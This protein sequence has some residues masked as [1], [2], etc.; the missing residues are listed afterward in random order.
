MPSISEKDTTIG[1]I[2]NRNTTAD[3]TRKSQQNDGQ[4]DLEFITSKKA[5]LDNAKHEQKSL[6]QKVGTLAVDIAT[7]NPLAKHVLT[8][9]LGTVMDQ[10]SG[11][12]QREAE[13]KK[14]LE[15]QK[16]L[17]NERVKSWLMTKLQFPTPEKIIRIH[18]KRARGLKGMDWKLFK[19][20]TSDPYCT[21]KIGGRMHRT[22]TVSDT[23]T[24]VW[25]PDEFYD[26]FLFDWKQ[27]MSVEVFDE[28]MGVVGRALFGEGQS[29]LDDDLG[30]SDVFLSDFISMK[31]RDVTKWLTLYERN[32]LGQRQEACGEIELR[33]QLFNLRPCRNVDDYRLFLEAIKNKRTENTEELELMEKGIIKRKAIKHSLGGRLKQLG[34]KIAGTKKGKDGKRRKILTKI[35][36]HK[37][38]NNVGNETN[39]TTLMSVANGRKTHQLALPNKEDSRS[40]AIGRPS[41]PGEDENDNTDEQNLGVTFVDSDGE[42]VNEDEDIYEEYEPTKAEIR[43][44]REDALANKNVAFLQANLNFVTF[45]PRQV[46]GDEELLLEEEMKLLHLDLEKKKERQRRKQRRIKRRTDRKFGLHAIQQHRKDRNSAQNN[47]DKDIDAH[48]ETEANNSETDNESADE[49]WQSAMIAM[50]NKKIKDSRRAIKRRIKDMKTKRKKWK[51]DINWNPYQKKFLYDCC[52]ITMEI[53]TREQ[54]SWYA[55]IKEDDGAIPGQ[56]DP[57]KDKD[58]DEKKD[59]APSPKAQNLDTYK[60][61]LLDPEN[62]DDEDFFEHSSSSSSDSDISNAGDHANQFLKL[63]RHASK[64]YDEDDDEEAKKGKE[65]L[66]MSMIP[67]EVDDSHSEKENNKNSSA[68]QKNNS[69]PEHACLI[70]E[71]PTFEDALKESYNGSFL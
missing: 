48:S 28:D 12:A 11:K 64:S 52:T 68:L 44:A 13:F 42:E 61:N 62:F 63:A 65:L 25:C 1:G 26:F 49:R 43:K 19:E 36:G 7:K 6:L 18:V 50:R 66:L 41:N 20:N 29:S 56:E 2:G 60:S 31:D 70:D 32:S 5:E 8:P 9:I 22:K 30:K 40:T 21:I 71:D 4:T 38:K 51:E 55:W 35:F 46:F 67:E 16:R 24:P 23:V 54:E 3:P 14:Q 27:T 15:K 39:R 37:N 10:V 45:V 47:Q 33:L 53:E 58:D 17:H 59:G 57:N 34:H 69:S